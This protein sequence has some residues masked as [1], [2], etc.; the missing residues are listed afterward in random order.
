MLAGKL[1]F[2]IVALLLGA[3]YSLATPTCA[4][5][6][7]QV[8]ILGAGV[9]GVAAARR[10]YDAGITDFIILEG[11]DQVG[12]R[13]ISV[14]FAGE[15]VDI[16]NAVITGV[17]PTNSGEYATNPIWTLKQ[18]CGVNVAPFTG[19]YNLYN[20]TSANKVA[21][22]TDPLVVNV[23]NTLY[24]AYAK[25]NQLAMNLEGIS[26]IS[27]RA[28]FNRSGWFPMTPLEKFVDWYNL[29]SLLLVQPEN[30]SAFG[31]FYDHSFADFGPDLFVINDT[32]GTEYLVQCLGQGFLNS[33]YLHLNTYVNSVEYST[34]CVCANVIENGI[35]PNRYC[36]KYAIVTFSVGVFQTG[37]V[38]YI[39]PL[40]QWKMNAYNSF[41]YSSY[42]TLY[43]QFDKQFWDSSANF[44]YS[45]DFSADVSFATQFGH[46][47]SQSLPINNILGMTIFG[48]TENNFTLMSVNDVKQ[49]V[50]TA[51]R[52]LYGANYT[53]QIINIYLPGPDLL[54]T[55]QV[56]G[57][58]NAPKVGISNSTFYN[59]T[60][61]LGNLYFAG[62]I[63]SMHY[64]SYAHGA[65]LAGNNS[66]NAILNRIANGAERNSSNEH[67]FLIAFLAAVMFSV[68]S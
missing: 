59:L 53:A 9:S 56:L 8:L 5:T 11:R 41:W 65:Y 46:Y 18:Q 60:I 14:D 63:C 28:A 44:A 51:L 37:S 48:P 10:L 67:V 32:R 38:S 50:N 6:D 1:L 34:E 52:S 39:P 57:T 36:G 68:S 58:F 62:E 25:A 24:G 35:T 20:S 22:S 33:Q 2:C 31:I 19:S 47:I 45:I 12:G 13:F 26:D 27:L 64:Y 17:D 43:I 49:Y 55:Y 21:S 40:P 29:E 30:V 23:S 66:A 16:G 61:P 42:F 15:K 54:H 3:C 7:P 4:S